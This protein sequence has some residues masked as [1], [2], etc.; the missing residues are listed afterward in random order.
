MSEDNQFKSEMYSKVSNID[1]EVQVVKRDVSNLHEMITKLQNF[2]QKIDS[3]S[4]KL[5]SLIMVQEK[6]LA[7]FERMLFDRDEIYN[8]NLDNMRSYLEQEIKEEEVS[9]KEAVKTAYR[10]MTSYKAEQKEFND[11]MTTKVENLEK[12]RWIFA[13]GVMIVSALIPI[14][15]NIIVKMVV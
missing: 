1:T 3:A 4:T 15:V 5:D 2:T 7:N 14:I 9:R 12:F 6:T 10:S 13:G 8:R 11:R